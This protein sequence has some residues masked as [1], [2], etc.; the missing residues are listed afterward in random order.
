[1]N[2]DTRIKDVMDKA[3][4]QAKKTMNKNIGGP[5][6]AAIIDKDGTI[7][8]VTSNSVLKDHDPT[9][10]AEINAIRE[11][12]E[13][14]GTHDLNG[15]TLVTTAYPCPMCLGAII[16]AN[17]KHVVYGCRPKDAEDI[18]FR[19]DF[20][21]RFIR[22]EHPDKK[23]LTIDEGFRETCLLLFKEYKEKEKTLY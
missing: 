1:M 7:I 12:G 6:G 13:K 11:A 19:D 23:I 2:N 17:I 4:A 18:G 3:I 8:S 20:I 21:Y 15:C 9:A 10:H 14:L 5:F 16:W 22:D